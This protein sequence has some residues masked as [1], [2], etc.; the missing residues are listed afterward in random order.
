MSRVF[1]IGDIHGALKAL[2]QVIAACEI[3]KDDQLIFLGD[4]VDG[5]PES[6]QT[7]EYLMELEN[8]YPCIF[9]KGNHDSWC[10]SWLAGELPNS[11]WLLHGGEATVKSYEDS[12]KTKRKNHL[13]FFYRMKDFYI[14]SKNR[15]FVHAG[16]SSMHG[17]TKEHYISNFSWDRTLWEMALVMDTRIAKD[18]KLYPKRL[19]LFHE[20]FIGHTP[21]LNYGVSIPMQAC[22]V[23]NIDTGA[24][25][26]GKLTVIDVDTK[27]YWQSEK[28]QLLYP[29][30]KG[31]A[32]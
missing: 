29:N 16:F 17:P 22:N 21:T 20:I 32:M 30:E 4:Y 9:L 31:R 26:F 14:D 25:F 7:I 28:V 19:R 11:E 1:A 24:A 12:N 23:W 15:L 8:K 5:W 6:A 27:N 3:K 10:E 18:S 13:A 2:Q